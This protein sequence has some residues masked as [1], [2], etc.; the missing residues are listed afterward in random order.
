[1]LLC[2]N[3][4]IYMHGYV[5]QW[6]FTPPPS[7]RRPEPHPDRTHTDTHTPTPPPVCPHFTCCLT[8]Y[9]FHKGCVA[10][11]IFHVRGIDRR[12]GRGGAPSLPVSPPPFPALSGPVIE[13]AASADDKGPVIRAA[14]ARSGGMRR[15][16]PGAAVPGLWLPHRGLLPRWT[17]DAGVFSSRRVVLFTA[18]VDLKAFCRADR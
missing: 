12:G 6:G 18:Q 2:V 17:A 9:I 10:R 11:S 14:R 16:E 1:M 4:V 13:L 3:N 7:P 15:A 8:S 5:G